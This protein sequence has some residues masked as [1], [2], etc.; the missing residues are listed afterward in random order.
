VRIEK[1]A[2]DVSTAGLQA[3]GR[4]VGQVADLAATSCTRRRVSAEICGALLS[5]RDTVVTANPVRSAMVRRVGR[6]CRAAVWS[7]VKDLGVSANDSL[8]L[9]VHKPLCNAGQTDAQCALCKRYKF[10]LATDYCCDAA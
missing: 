4:P 3:L 6:T 2:D 8:S 7:C 1:H 10:D 5:A 9:R